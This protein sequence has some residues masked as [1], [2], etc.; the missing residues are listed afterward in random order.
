MAVNHSAAP[1][2]REGFGYVYQLHGFFQSVKE[3]N[4]SRILS[5]H[6]KTG[7]SALLVK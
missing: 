2:A 7:S 6:P 1:I 4:S 5:G 3:I